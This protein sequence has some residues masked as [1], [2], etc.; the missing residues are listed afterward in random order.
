MGCSYST[1]QYGIFNFN[2]NGI[3]LL[4]TMVGAAIMGI[5][6]ASTKAHGS[7]KKQN[8]LRRERHKHAQEASKSLKALEAGALVKGPMP[9]YIPNPWLPSPF[10]TTPCMPRQ[11]QGPGLGYEMA[12]RGC[13]D[14]LA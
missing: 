3:N 6:W 12:L 10:P 11:A 13:K 8:K 1:N 7:C 4:W 9:G 14:S 2:A 5:V